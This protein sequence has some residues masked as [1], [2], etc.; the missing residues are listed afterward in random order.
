MWN[1]S[2]WGCAVNARAY[3]AACGCQPVHSARVVRAEGFRLRR[4]PRCGVIDAVA[5]LGHASLAHPHERL[6]K[7]VRVVTQIDGDRL[8][9]SDGKRVSVVQD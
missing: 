1:L 6:E 2:A 3:Q 4:R 7:R 9:V 5:V 8:T